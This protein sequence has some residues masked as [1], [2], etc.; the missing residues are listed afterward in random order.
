MTIAWMM[1]SDALLQLIIRER[2]R[3]IK[4][5]IMVSGSSLPAYW[6]SNYFADIIF[7]SL[8]AI[9]A[10]L[11]IWM[12]N[13]EVDGIY[14]LFGLVVLANPVFVY[15]VTSFFD[16]DESGSLAINV[17][18]FVFGIIAPIALSVL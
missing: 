15:F 13:I 5:Q 10:L 9:V 16:K 18:F 4:H 11:G 3:N 8:G 17:I 1:I 12:F 6:L 2:Q 7:H 14:Y